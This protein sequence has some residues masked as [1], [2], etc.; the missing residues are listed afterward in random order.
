MIGNWGLGTFFRNARERRISESV[1][2]PKQERTFSAKLRRPSIKP[3]SCDKME[4][5]T[6][7]LLDNQELI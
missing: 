3:L 5:L 2:E 1:P 4:Y 6:V 7:L